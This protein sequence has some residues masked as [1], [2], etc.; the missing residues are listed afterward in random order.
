M[1]SSLCKIA[2]KL[3]TVGKFRRQFS[4]LTII[5]LL[6]V[7]AWSP[8]FSRIHKNRHVYVNTGAAYNRHT[9]PILL[10]YIHLYY[11]VVWISRSINVDLVNLFKILA[12]PLYEWIGRAKVRENWPSQHDRKLVISICLYL[13][14]SLTVPNPF[15]DP[16]YRAG[17]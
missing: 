1:I 15:C 9:V 16:H 13:L 11:M 4:A 3:V 8:N 2:S 5:S 17:T 14:H 10:Y 6:V 7:N 12:V